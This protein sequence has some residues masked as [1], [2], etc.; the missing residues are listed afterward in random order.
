MSK[1]YSNVNVEIIDMNG[2][3]VSHNS[4]NIREIKKMY[5]SFIESLKVNDIRI[6]TQNFFEYVDDIK[7]KFLYTSGLGTCHSI[8]IFNKNGPAMISHIDNDSIL[9]PVFMLAKLLEWID[10]F[11]SQFNIL[12]IEPDLGP[13]KYNYSHIPVF[14]F[15]SWFNKINGLDLK[16]VKLL[17]PNFTEN[18]PGMVAL[19]SD[20]ENTYIMSMT[21]NNKQSKLFNKAVAN[22]ISENLTT[23]W[24]F[25]CKDGNI[26]FNNDIM[27]SCPIP[28]R[29]TRGVLGTKLIN[30]SIPEII[31]YAEDK[32]AIEHQI[33]IAEFHK[34]YIVKSITQIINYC[35]SIKD[36]NYVKDLE[37]VLDT[38]NKNK[39]KN[40]SSSK[41]PIQ[42]LYDLVCQY[43]SLFEESVYV[44]VK[45]K[46]L[47]EVYLHIFVDVMKV[48]TAIK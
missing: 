4:T 31:K 7:G 47:R 22:K 26:K 10:K 43:N 32:M 14:N 30:A 1:L 38:I 36:T 44:S 19:Y 28:N 16:V 20:Y 6:V 21:V 12:F 46:V 15:Y 9:C 37:S 41:S 23:D 27:F 5:L 29:Y 8:L 18:G 45:D 34:K 11:G 48:G 13:K 24:E 3:K 35:I 33:E 40:K 25:E 39:Y 17:L 42:Y 2:V